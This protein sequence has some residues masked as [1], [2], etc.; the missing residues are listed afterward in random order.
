MKRRKKVGFRGK[1]L[2]FSIFPKNC[3]LWKKF[4]MAGCH[5][6][7]KKFANASLFFCQTSL[8]PG[9]SLKSAKTLKKGR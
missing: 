4:C 2:V 1:D 3:K 7:V 9:Y 6:K 5:N 8:L